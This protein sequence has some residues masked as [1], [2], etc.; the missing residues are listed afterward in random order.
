MAQKLVVVGLGYVGL[1][2]A[3][4]AANKGWQV[5]GI[6]I[7][8]EKV[9][10]I[11]AENE[12]LEATTEFEAVAQ[13]DVIVIAVPT[14]VLDD[15]L[16]DLH[17]L[18]SALEDVREHLQAGQLLVVESTINPGVMAE[19]VEPLLQE[20]ADLPSIH[21][22]HC[23]ERINPGDPKWNVSNIPRVLGADT[24]E[25]QKLAKDFYDSILDAEVTVMANVTEA[26]AV[27]ILENTFR[28]INIAYINEMARSFDKLGINIT[29]VIAGASTKP[30]AFLP[31]YPGNGV[32]GHCISVDPYYMIERAR[33]VGF[34][35]KFLKLAR[36]INDGM[37]EYVVERLLEA[38][39]RLDLDPAHEKVA[40][41]GLSYKK[42]VNDLRESPALAIK[43]L[44]EAKGV[45]LQVFDPFFPDLNTAGVA[46]LEEAITDCAAVMLATDHDEF[47]NGLTPELLKEK[48][49]NVLLDGKNA[50]DVATMKSAGVLYLGVGRS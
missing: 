43:A 42:N 17:P 19:V 12:N 23:P 50:L 36:E 40:L 47:I 38:M 45:Q 31:H 10:K 25:A 2:L 41:L 11:A 5:T 27:K 29:N 28:D 22:A 3:Q 7:D 13:A 49:T 18:K 37:A 32:G 21:L 15:Y 35:H 33:Q 20:R 24:P 4:L 14:P 39:K 46:T 34:D 16:P 6:D 1:P 9:G 30:F 26:E 8:D 44:L 48:G